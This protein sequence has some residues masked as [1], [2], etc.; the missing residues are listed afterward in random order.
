MSTGFTPRLDVLPE[1]QHRLWPELGKTPS[2]FTLYGGTA[3]ALRLGHRQSMDFDFFA[4]TPFQPDALLAEIPY[5]KGAVVRQLSAN[6]LTATVERGGPVQVSFFGDLGLGQ[7]E[8][9]NF[10]ESPGLAI[11]SL[12]DLAGTKVKVL[13]QR[14]EPK[15]YIDIHALLTKGRLSL[16]TILAAASV[17]FGPQFSPLLALK[18]IAYHDDPALAGLSR[19]LKSDLAKAVQTTDPQK[20]PALN[21]V[22]TWQ[23]AR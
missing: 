20:L 23:A 10:V 22:R 7:V 19:E 11:A 17:I 13:V 6:T 1:S 2:K 12:V 8:T 21:P 16:A 3:I 14:V 18:A 5:L 15:D 4:Q 9:P